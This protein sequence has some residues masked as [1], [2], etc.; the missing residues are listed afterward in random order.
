MGACCYVRRVST[1]Q[2][3]ALVADR[4][5]LERVLFPS[6]TE[7]AVD[8]DVFIDL[9]TV[10]PSLV[11]A[12]VALNPALALLDRGG[13]D[14][15]K[16]NGHPA[17]GFATADARRIAAAL[18]LLTPDNVPDPVREKFEMLKDFVTETAKAGAGMIVFWR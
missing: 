9:D 4:S 5:K 10:W 18:S 8:D 13:A 1:R 6:T 12:V 17:V 2:L 16:L 3:D 15:G 14:L 11:E 7:T